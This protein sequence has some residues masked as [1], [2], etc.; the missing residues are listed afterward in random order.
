MTHR[1]LKNVVTLTLTEEKCIGCGK[2]EEVCPHRVFS[3]QDHQAR[4]TDRDSCIECGAC[5]RNCLAEAIGVEA[6]VGC[7]TAIIKGWLTGGEPTCGCA[8]SGDCC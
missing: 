3:V 8:D 2:C 6:S 1:Y 5:A 7:A 4:I